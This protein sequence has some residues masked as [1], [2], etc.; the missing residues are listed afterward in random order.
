MFNDGGEY[1]FGRFG[2][3]DAHAA[4]QSFLL[5]TANTYFDRT[6]LS[7]LNKTLRKPETDEERF[8]RELREGWDFSGLELIKR[9]D[10]PN[11]DPTIL[12]LSQKRPPESILVGP[13]DLSDHIL[14]AQDIES[15]RQSPRHFY[16]QL[17]E[18]LRNRCA[19]IADFHPVPQLLPFA[20][21][22]KD[23]GCDLLNELT[24]TWLDQ[25]V[26]PHTSSCSTLAVA[27]EA[28]FPHHTANV[29]QNTLDMNLYEKFT[30][31][32][33]QRPSPEFDSEHVEE[34]IK[35]FLQ[36]RSGDDSMVFDGECIAGSCRVISY[37]I[38]ELLEISTQSCSLSGIVPSNVRMSLYNDPEMMSVMQYCY[39]F[40]KGRN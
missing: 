6:T 8:Q 20:E 35:D 25:V 33:C 22:Q 34:R 29:G 10:A 37:L 3:D 17:Q 4:A 7:G 5:F 24:L 11:N 14:R 15:L 40:W 27:A 13:Y 21:S 36:V 16:D 23:A 2:F 1:L 26:L 9:M 18:Q 31:G 19:N 30:E 12:Q 38:V 32:P 39:V 28:L